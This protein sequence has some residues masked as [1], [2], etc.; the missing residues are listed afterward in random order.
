MEASKILRSL[1]LLTVGLPYLAIKGLLRLARWA[2]QAIAIH[3]GLQIL[4]C[5]LVCLFVLAAWKFGPILTG[6]LARQS[7]A[8]ALARG[9]GERNTLEVE[10]ALRRRA[11]R[12]GFRT[13]ITEPLAVS[14]ERSEVNGITLCTISYE[15][16]REVDLFGFWRMRIPVSGR[17][18]EPVEPPGEKGRGLEEI[19]VQ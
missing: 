19:L 2:W 4:S 15:F 7:S 9:A 13:A 12:L 6:R 1:L 17:V 14:V 8:E 16:Q 3:R 5:L 18:E 10:N 11:Y